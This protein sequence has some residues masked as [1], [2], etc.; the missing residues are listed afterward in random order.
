MPDEGSSRRAAGRSGAPESESADLIARAIGGDVDAVAGLYDQHLPYVFRYVWVRVGDPSTAEDLTGEV[1]L[2]MVTA[3]PHY[4]HVGLPF[5]AWL[6]RIARNLVI[7]HYRKARRR[8][9]V[10]LEQIEPL[11]DAEAGPAAELEGKLTLGKLREALDQLEISQREVVA[12]R[13]LSGL[14]LEETAQTLR[15]SIASVKALQHRGLANLRSTLIG[16]EG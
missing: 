1:F 3:L 5:R 14:S 13:F 7:D 8:D 6:F 9:N 2:R 16:A 15:K 10:S 4:R 12:L 11:Q